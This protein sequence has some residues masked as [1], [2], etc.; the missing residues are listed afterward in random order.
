M[1]VILETEKGKRIEIVKFPF[2][3]GRSSECDFKLESN[4]VSRK[5]AKLIVE[6]EKVLLEDL[7]SSNGTYVNL[8]QIEKPTEIYKNDLLKFADVRMKVILAPERT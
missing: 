5:H 8:N 1:K 6:G 2:L 4:L 7:K 3:L